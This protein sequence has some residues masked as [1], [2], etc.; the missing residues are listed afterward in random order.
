M[1]DMA[2]ESSM[3]AN[4]K[5]QRLERILA[6]PF[7]VRAQMGKGRVFAT[8]KVVKLNHSVCVYSRIFIYNLLICVSLNM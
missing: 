2:Y 6:H 3:R 1:D 7:K 8:N 4:R 5:G